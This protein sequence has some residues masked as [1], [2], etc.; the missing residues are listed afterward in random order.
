MRGYHTMPDG[1]RMKDSDHMQARGKHGLYYNIHKKQMRIAHGS[2][3]KMRTPGTKGAPS[4]KAFKQAAKT[5]HGRG[6]FGLKKGTPATKA[7]MA[8]L[9]SMRKC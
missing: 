1:T 9:R 4:A 6:R 7:Y 2:H 8:K 3:E 5:A